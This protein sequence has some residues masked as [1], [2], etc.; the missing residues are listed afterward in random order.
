MEVDVVDGSGK[1]PEEKLW[2]VSFCTLHHSTSY[3][4]KGRKKHHAKDI[5]FTGN[6]GRE[7]LAAVLKENTADLSYLRVAV[8]HGDLIE[9]EY[10]S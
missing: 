2:S 5:V 6:S 7:H 8:D 1:E 10:L 9:L 3:E 4:E